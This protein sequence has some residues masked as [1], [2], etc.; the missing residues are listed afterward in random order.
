M[1]MVRLGIG[2]YGVSAIDNSRLRNV[3][4]L[5][6][7][8]SMVRKAKAGETV[9]Y[10]RRTVLT[11]DSLIAIVPI[12]YADG[13][14]RRLSNGVGRVL[15]NGHMAPV[16][17]N[18]CMDITMVDVTDVPNVKGGDTVELFGDTEPVWE[19][20]ARIGTIPYEILTGIGRRVK[21]IYFVE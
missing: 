18:V 7:Y 19:M 15:I 11:R 5:K 21:R 13:V 9:G 1:E 6:S 16:A 10:N 17:G 14:D 4:T 3:A 2:L 8:V 20:S 12:G